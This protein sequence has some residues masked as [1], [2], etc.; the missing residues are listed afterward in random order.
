MKG[1]R[2]ANMDALEL[3]GDFCWAVRDDG[4]IT[5]ILFFCPTC[6]S[7]HGVPLA[8]YGPTGGRGWVWNFDQDN[9]TLTPSMLFSAGH[10][11]SNEDCRWHGWLT[12]REWITA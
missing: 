10:G 11:G 5:N 9:P 1:R 7:L 6:G 2:K 4:N 3:P 12:N 8:P